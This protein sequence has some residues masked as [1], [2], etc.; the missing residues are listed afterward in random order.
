M[1]DVYSSSLD[2]TM[3]DQP[4]NTQSPRSNKSKLLSK[5]KFVFDEFEYFPHKQQLNYKGTR[6][7][8]E[9]KMLQLLSILIKQRPNVVSKESLMSALW[10]DAVV[11]DW[12]LARLV[13]D[14]RKLIEDDGRQQS[15]IKTIRGK[16]FAFTVQTDEIIQT[17]PQGEHPETPTPTNATTT[18]ESA[19][20]ANLFLTQKKSKYLFPV[21]V[22]MAVVFVAFISKK[23]FFSEAH[24]QDIHQQE[25]HY[26]EVMYEIQKNLR[27]TKSTYL[28]QKRRRNEL[29]ESLLA[30]SPEKTPLSSEKRIRLHYPHLTPEEKFVF[31]QIRAMTEGP[32]FKGNYSILKLLDKHPEIYREIET[33]HALYNHLNL[34]VNKYKKIFLVQPD[35]C[36]VFVGEEDGVP[37]PSEIDGLVDDWIADKTS[38]E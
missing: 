5:R 29:K 32:I 36:F 38:G 8:L 7:N 34:W 31:D 11:S 37:F 30:K 18:S 33:F 35:M 21:I 14:T 3:Q 16:G 19:K 6:C 17:Y 22:I 27:L 2:I 15:I 25:G 13:S 9:P 23:L 1:L 12:S 24:V 26:L 20:S 10:P 4:E 28:A